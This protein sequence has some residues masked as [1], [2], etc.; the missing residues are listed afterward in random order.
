MLTVA[1]IYAEWVNQEGGIKINGKTYYIEMVP[2]DTNEYVIPLNPKSGTFFIP[3]VTWLCI[4]V[5]AATK[6]RPY[7]ACHKNLYL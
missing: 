3:M 4:G 2:K 5:T 7:G 1:Q 6:S